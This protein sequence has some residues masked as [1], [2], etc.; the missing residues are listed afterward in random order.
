MTTGIELAQR[1]EKAG[2]DSVWVPDFYRSYSVA[3]AAV[4]T[5]TDR[6]KLGTNVS[7]GFSRS[8]YLGARVAADLDELSRGRLILGVG[9]GALHPGRHDGWTPARPRPK[10]AE[11]RELVEIYRHCWQSWHDT[12]GAHVDVKKDHGIVNLDG[13]LTNNRPIRRA[14]PIHLGVR[15]SRALQ[16]AGEVADGVC[17][18]PSASP[19]YI[20]EEVRPNLD[21]G[22]QRAGRDVT[23]LQVT[24]MVICCVSSDREEARRMA[25]LQ[26]AYY[27]GEDG[28]VQPSALER[29]GFGDAWK[30]VREARAKDDTSAMESAISDEMLDLYA[31]AGTAEDVREGLATRDDYCERVVLEAPNWKLEKNQITAIYQDIIDALAQAPSAIRKD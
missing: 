6:V 12:P 18:F 7:M 14:V 20:K 28:S 31:I 24:A 22:A 15:K 11:L 2:F 13:S 17:L 4:A 26:L 19:R 23:S 10:L 9:T 29:D 27:S 1:A 21:I 30:R 3:L 5:A 16:M 25:R 8:P